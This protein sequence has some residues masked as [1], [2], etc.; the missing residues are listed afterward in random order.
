[1]ADI[2]VSPPSVWD[3]IKKGQVIRFLPFKTPA[4]NQYAQEQ[5]FNKIEMTVNSDRD[6]RFLVLDYSDDVVP[7]RL[8][9]RIPAGVNRFYPYA[10]GS[11]PLEVVPES[12]VW[13]IFRDYY[14]LGEVVRAKDVIT[15]EDGEG[16]FESFV[17]PLDDGEA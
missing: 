16:K 6:T 17:K 3:R 1:M 14:P 10:N 9:V 7:S 13:A 2:A 8:V 11:G 5:V 4:I 12:G 15:I